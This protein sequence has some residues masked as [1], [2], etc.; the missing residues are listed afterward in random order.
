M[1]KLF[2]KKMQDLQQNKLMTKVLISSDVKETV[3]K[4]FLADL[5]VEE[6]ESGLVTLSPPTTPPKGFSSFVHRRRK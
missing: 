4:S 6:E 1:T 3:S 2:A 5:M